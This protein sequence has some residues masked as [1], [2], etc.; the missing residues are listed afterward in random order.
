[1]LV[2]FSLVKKLK[3]LR[4][5]KLFANFFSHMVALRLVLFVWIFYILCFNRTYDVGVYCVYLLVLFCSIVTLRYHQCECL[6]FFFDCFND[7][8]FTVT[9]KHDL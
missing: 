3:L 5:N 4:A 6:I 7:H 8:T 9:L 1:M 2:L